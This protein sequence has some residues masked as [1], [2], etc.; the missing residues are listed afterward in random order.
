MGWWESGK[1]LFGWLSFCEIV[2]WEKKIKKK[3]WCVFYGRMCGEDS[4]R[5]MTNVHRSTEQQTALHRVTPLIIKSVQKLWPWQDSALAVPL[6]I[7]WSDRI[8][9]YLPP[10]TLLFLHS[11]PLIFSLSIPPSLLICLYHH[12]EWWM[13]CRQRTSQTQDTEREFQVHRYKNA[14]PLS[15][16]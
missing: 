4:E 12:D 8:Q 6:L 13:Y 10:S 9:R 14:C 5:H 1:S 11:S 7:S 2:K 3:T 15:R 16:K